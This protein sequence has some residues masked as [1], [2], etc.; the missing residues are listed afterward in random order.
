MVVST[1]PVI[2]VVLGHM[3]RRRLLDVPAVATITD[4]TGLF[5]WAAR[6]IDMHLVMYEASVRDVERIAGRGSAQIVRPLI[7]AEF[8]EPREPGAAREALGLGRA[9]RLVVVSGGGW[10]VGDI[11][12]AVAELARIPDTTVVASRAATMMSAS[13]S[14]RA[15]LATT[16]SA[17]SDSPIRCLGCSAPR[18]C[19]SI[20]PVA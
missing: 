4:M 15:S 6:G 3:R 8:L 7:A 10:G 9:G 11:A 16:A 1:Y 2:T 14:R 17:C 18:T 13:R 19:W 5:F 12:G 20:R